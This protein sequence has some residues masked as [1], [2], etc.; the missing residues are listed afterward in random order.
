MCPFD[1]V[2]GH[3]MVRDALMTFAIPLASIA[4]LERVG[5]RATH[6]YKFK[7]CYDSASNP[8]PPSHTAAPYHCATAAGLRQQSSLVMANSHMKRRGRTS[9]SAVEGKLLNYSN[10]WKRRIMPKRTSGWRLCY[11]KKK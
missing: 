8:R 5:S 6:E 1:G 7:S 11:S 9:Y 10:L 2:H 4:P 3:T